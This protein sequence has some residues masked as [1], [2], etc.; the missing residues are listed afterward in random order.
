M[1]IFRNTLPV[2]FAILP[3]AG[4][5]TRMQRHDG[6][7]KAYLPLDN[8]PLI[9]HSIEILQAHPRIAHI[10]VAVNPKHTNFTLPLEKKFSKI[11]FCPGGARRQDSVF[12][13]LNYIANNFI[14]NAENISPSHIMIHDAARPYIRNQLLN[15]LIDACK[16]F[17]ESG[18]IPKLPLRD[19]LKEILPDGTLHT[20]NRELIFTIQTPQIFPFAQI[21]QLHQKYHAQNFTDDAG[22]FEKAGLKITLVDGDWQNIKITYPED[23]PVL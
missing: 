3:A 20:L 9:Q 21:Y 15:P 13:A 22:L 5:G 4:S 14:T 12:A 7:P 2:I 18:I 23:L 16:H 1:P 11:S 10:L 6:I 17:P 8:K 19:T